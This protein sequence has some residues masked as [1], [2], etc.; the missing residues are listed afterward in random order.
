MAIAFKN[1]HGEAAASSTVVYTAPAATE[2]VVFGASFA[3]IDGTNSVDLTIEVTDTSAGTTEK[4]IDALSIPVNDT[5]FLDYKPTL[6]ATDTIRV[7]AGATGD[8]D[9][10]LSIMEKS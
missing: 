2:S 6:E 3:N 8:I 4:V 10:H 9:Y 5:Y 1:A 7:F